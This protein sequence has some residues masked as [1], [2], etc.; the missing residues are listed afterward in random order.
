MPHVKYNMIGNVDYIMIAIMIIIINR[1]VSEL[2]R[3]L[4]P[5]IA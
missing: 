1:V 3:G 2:A 5:T 4:P